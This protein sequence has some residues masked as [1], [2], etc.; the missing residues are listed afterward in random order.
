VETTP[1]AGPTPKVKKTPK[2]AGHLLEERDERK[3]MRGQGLKI[4][5]R[6]F[7]ISSQLVGRYLRMRLP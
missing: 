6:G 2:V 3:G 7:R 1:K 4:Q 5:R